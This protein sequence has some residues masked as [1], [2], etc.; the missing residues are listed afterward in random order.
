VWKP[1]GASILE[2]VQEGKHPWERWLVPRGI[3]VE[4][5]LSSGR[6]SQDVETLRSAS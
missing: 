6:V 4:D 2:V 3:V 5:I 1:R